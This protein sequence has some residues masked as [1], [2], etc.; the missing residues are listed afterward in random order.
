MTCFRH[1]LNKIDKC[2][3]VIFGKKLLVIQNNS[4]DEDL[5]KKYLSFIP[6]NDFNIDLGGNI[7]Y[8]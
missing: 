2:N 8:F 5:F 1:L 4:D 7:N 6:E 3:E